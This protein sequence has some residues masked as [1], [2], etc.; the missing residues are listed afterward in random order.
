MTAIGTEHVAIAASLATH[1]LALFG[2]VPADES[3]GL[4]ALAAG[5]PARSILLAA[6]AGS[7]FWPHFAAAPEFSDGGRHPLNR[8]SF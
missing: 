5:K 4:P 8:W 6:N 3:D 7:A 2:P 1:G